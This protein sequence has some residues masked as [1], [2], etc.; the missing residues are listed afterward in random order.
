MGRA[1]TRSRRGAARRAV[2]LRPLP[3]DRPRRPER[4]PRRLGND[5]R[6]RRRDEHAPPRDARHTGH[7]PQAVRPREARHDRRSHLRRPRRARARRRLVRVGARR[8][9]IRLHDLGRPPRR[10]RPPARARSRASGRKPTTSGRSPIQQPRPRIIVGGRAK[11]R[12]VA[13]AVRYAD[14]YNTV[15]PTVAEARERKQR[16]DEAAA[17]KP[18]ASLSASR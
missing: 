3:L 10:A 16:V 7:V 1:R 15:W 17:A 12:T 6:P 11:P 9:R 13:A 2:P 8:V 14:E 18:A 4:R 5:L